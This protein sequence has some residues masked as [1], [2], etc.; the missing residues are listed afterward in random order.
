MKRPGL[1]SFGLFACLAVQ[2]ADS[3]F[4][5]PGSLEA[6]SGTGVADNHVYLPG[7]RFPLEEPIAFLNSQV[8]R[9][10]GNHGPAGNQCDQEN[11]SMPWRDNY[12]EKRTHDMP[13]CP[14]GKGHQGQDIRPATCNKDRHWAVAADDGIIAH[15]GS[16]SVTLQNKNGTLFRYLHLSMSDLNV[17]AQERVKKGDR[18]GKVSNTYPGSSTTIHLHFD[19]KDYVIVGGKSQFVFVPPYTSLVK[20]YKD[21]R[22]EAA[23]AAKKQPSARKAAVITKPVATKTQ[24]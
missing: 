10:G 12:C 20:S 2:A 24:P 11:Y 15:I 6:G 19:V 13:M 14:G 7:M 23:V 17:S 9:K 5:P 18:I 8:Y 3:E 4:L 1:L 21:L 22:A 16:Y